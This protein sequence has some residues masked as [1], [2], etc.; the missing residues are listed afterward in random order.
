MTAK[1]LKSSYELAMERLAKQDREQGE[2]PRATLDEAQKR[3]IQELRS[4]ARAQLAELEILN[5]K[6]VAGAAS[7]DPAA[8]QELDEAY[9]RDR[10]RIESALESAIARVRAGKPGRLDD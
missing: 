9:R 8:L 7:A 10:E 3:E 5:R 4:R 1:K 2:Q 6:N